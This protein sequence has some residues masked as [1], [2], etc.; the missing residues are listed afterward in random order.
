MKFALY[1]FIENEESALFV[2][3]SNLVG[4]LQD[5]MKNNDKYPLDDDEIV[6]VKCASREG[7]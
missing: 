1:E 4:D 5:D 3:E 6:E 7:I 2:G